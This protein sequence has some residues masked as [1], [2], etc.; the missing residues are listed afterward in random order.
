MRNEP[1]V[2]ERRRAR[3]DPVDL[4]LVVRG[5]VGVGPLLTER[6][7][8]DGRRTGLAEQ[9]A[10]RAVLDRLEQGRV[11]VHD[12][13]EL[14]Q[15]AV[16]DP[17]R[18]VREDL[19]V[20]VLPLDGYPVL[21]GDAEAPEELDLP[22]ALVNVCWHGLN[23]PFPIVCVIPDRNGKGKD[24]AGLRTLREGPGQTL[25]GELTKREHSGKRV[26]V[27]GQAKEGCLS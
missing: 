9:P 24:L 16:E 1:G 20:L 12:E 11:R 23:S 17:V 4:L 18:A 26:M 8:Q 13:L 7:E 6:H 5:V 2:V 21:V 14:E 27:A 25:W 19:V 3:V 10:P 22:L 15:D